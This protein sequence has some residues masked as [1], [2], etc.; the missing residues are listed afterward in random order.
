MIHDLLAQ[1]IKK[2][3]QVSNEELETICRYFKPRQ[4]DKSEFLLTQGS[5]CRFEGFVLK[6]CF[7]IFTIDDAGNERTLYFAVKGWW[8]M[9]VDS[10]MHQTPSELNIQ[11]L[12]D[13]EVLLINKADKEHLYRELPVVEKLFRIMSQQALIAWQRRLMRNHRLTAKERYLHFTETYPSIVA[14]L[15][16]KKI[17]SYLGITPEFLSKIKKS[18][19]NART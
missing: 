1:Q 5:T 12:E 10:F 3:V 2:D 11:A 8:L 18:I 19:S 6:G 4:V 17:S 7:R 15:T 16:D 14:K 9:D 13:S